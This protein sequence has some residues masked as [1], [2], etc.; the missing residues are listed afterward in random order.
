[1][2]LIDWTIHYIDYLNNFKKNL[3]EKDT[4]G[5]KITC[6]FNNDNELVYVI[7]E[8]LDIQNIQ[9]K[10]ILVVLNSEKNLEY[11]IKNWIKFT[12]EDKLKIIFVNN[13]LNLQWSIIPYLH[14]K[15]SDPDNLSNG[16]ISLSNS[17]PKI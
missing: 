2:N 13:L 12:K 8:D 11:L 17:V 1:M 7:S 5:N 6:K 9:K 3:L 10:T 16:L 14:D 4:L 15:F